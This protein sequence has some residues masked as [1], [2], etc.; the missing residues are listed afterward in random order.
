MATTMD[1]SITH[2][3]R[4]TGMPKRAFDLL[5]S[6]ELDN[7]SDWMR[8]NRSGVL[9]HLRG[10]FISYLEEATRRL[11]EEGFDLMGGEGTVFRMQRDLRFT[12][13]RR[14]FHG[15][16]EAVFS[17]G[18]QRIGTQASIHVRL[19][20]SGGF[21][22]AGSFLQPTASLLALRAAM[23]AREE[24]FLEIAAGLERAGC[25]LGSARSLKRLPRGFEDPGVGDLGVHLRRVDPVAE[26]PLSTQDWT[27]P[28][29]IEETLDFA[30]AVRP[31]LLFT[32]EALQPLGALDPGGRSAP[33]QP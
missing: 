16:I 21:L 11:R 14:P 28:G 12:R 1:K 13:D 15:H 27:G 20:P 5:Q 25:P 33:P 24:R 26:R 8:A 31:W 18:G 7:T 9:E 4:F 10:P 19:D 32:R 23:V 17:H 29:V 6:L 2:A 3:T 22:R 30:R